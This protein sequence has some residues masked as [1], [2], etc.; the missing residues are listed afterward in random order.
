M[1]FTL[2]GQ[3]R[4][5][6]VHFPLCQGDSKLTISAA[7]MENTPPENTSNI[8]SG[9][10]PVDPRREAARGGRKVRPAERLCRGLDAS[11]SGF[12][13]CV[14]MPHFV[15]KALSASFATGDP[16]RNQRGG[17][18]RAGLSFSFP[19]THTHIRTHTSDTKPNQRG[20]TY[21]Y[22]AT[23]AA[24]REHKPGGEATETRGSKRSSRNLSVTEL[25]TL[26]TLHCSLSPLSSFLSPRPST[27][28]SLRLSL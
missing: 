14:A 11:S 26:L 3:P 17:G 13:V 21:R 1:G 18:D 15:Y 9:R 16:G 19:H 4:E 5:H 24:G 7:T 8:R 23:P 20:Q 28:L 25:P 27:S 6:G 10:L 22:R 12:C 2:P